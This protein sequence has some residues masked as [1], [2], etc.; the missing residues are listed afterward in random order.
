VA[1][2]LAPGTQ[3]FYPT[4][5]SFLGA[6]YLGK[7]RVEHVRTEVTAQ[8]QR[9][10]SLGIEPTHVD[11]HKHTH[12]FPAVLAA[13]LK[14]AAANGVRAI[15][16][17][18]EPEWAVAATPGA[19]FLR[20][21][22]VRTLRTLHRRNFLRT[23]AAAEFA[24]TEGCIGVAA[25]GSLDSEALRSLV[26][27]LPG[28]TWELCCHPG[29]VDSELAAVKTRLRASREAEVAA[30]MHLPAMLPPGTEMAHFGYLT[31]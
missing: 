23:V 26:C 15:R 30:L 25:T 2:L 9:L 22:E 14:A 21:A 10:R 6:L 28:G 19:G 29:H 13:V 17:P 7:I 31:R 16:N 11:T 8:L 4:L 18:F 24:T 5:G 27:N 20:K 3:M 12:M 1:S